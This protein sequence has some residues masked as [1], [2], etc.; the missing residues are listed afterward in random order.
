MPPEV[1]TYMSL[2]TALVI[3]LLAVA[4]GTATAAPKQPAD[5][6]CAEHVKKMEGMK[7]SAEREAYCKEH[8]DCESHHCTKQVAHKK[9]HAKKH[10]AAPAA[11]KPA[12]N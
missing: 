1:D 5:N 8:E 9:G 11:P 7:T 4:S 3:A 10:A 2:R 12:P 6:A